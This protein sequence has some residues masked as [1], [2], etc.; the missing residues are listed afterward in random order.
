MSLTFDPEKHIYKLDGKRV[1]GVTT[2][3]GGGIPKP[4]LVGWSARTVAQFVEDN[5]LT[6][7]QW[8]GEDSPTEGNP[9][10]LSALV[11]N[12]AKVPTQ[13]RDDAA[14]RGTEIH[15]LGQRYLEGEAVDIPPAH[16]QE[17][18]GLVDFIEAWELEPLIV[19]HSLASRAHRYAG[20]VDF[21]GTSPYLNGGKP[22]LIDWKTSNNVYGDTA[23][24]AAAYAMAEFHVTDDDPGTELELPHITQCFVAH[25]RPGLTELHQ[26]TQDR[27]QMERQF[28]IFLAAASIYRT[29]T[30]RKKWLGEALATPKQADN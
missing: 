23:L 5:P 20:R 13:K 15:D 24:Q 1:P 10:G 30:E 8:R 2:L 17:V 7:E 14:L 26:L 18:L 25:I 4:A 6:I 27:G 22:V 12:L 28:E 9:R 3:I 21:I 11:Y 16:E 19:E 29:A